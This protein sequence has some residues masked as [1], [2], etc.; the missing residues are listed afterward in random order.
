[1]NPEE[2]VILD[3]FTQLYKKNLHPDPKMRLKATELQDIYK[4]I[5]N[6]IMNYN[7]KTTKNSIKVDF[8]TAFV[9]FLKS[10][11][12][13]IKTLFYKNFAFLN[14]NLI[15]T[16]SIFQTIKSTAVKL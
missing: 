16:E 5:I 1:L 3:F 15:C 11:N 2:L 7:L 10:K 14:F 12:I 13:S 8:I 6:F 4:Y 9:K